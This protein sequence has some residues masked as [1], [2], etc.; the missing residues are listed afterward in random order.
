MKIAVV[1]AGTMG[2]TF[3]GRLAEAGNEVWFIDV[4]K[5]H[6]EK[7]ANEGLTIEGVDGK[8]TISVNATENPSDAGI[9]DLVI[10]FTKSTATKIATTSSLPMKG[11]DTVYLTI[12]NGIGNHDII[13]SIVGEDKV[14]SGITFVGSA[15]IGPAHVNH[16]SNGATVFG[17]IDG[18]ISAR[19]QR[20][21]ETLQKAGFENTISTNVVGEM[22]GKVLVN[23]VTS[24]IAV[25]T[26]ETIGGLID[27]PAGCEWMELVG[28]EVEAVA[29]AKGIALPYDNVMEKLL[30]N[31]T[32]AGPALP[33]MRQDIDKK[34]WTEIDF[35]NGGVVREGMKV[36]VPTPY[37]RALM[38]MIR[39]IDARNHG[40]QKIF[41]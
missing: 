13:A 8:R 3:G 36:G 21:S 24:P 4:W 38:L 20:I 33:S 19:T 35:I 31:S 28:S 7:M 27:F 2:C 16:T 14:L 6:V 17:E 34:A 23:C 41:T 32:N 1:G 18:T 25:L 22:W 11:D 37:N 5:E 39:M 30:K 9:M 15:F 29:K 40:E 12:Q 26:S 10:I